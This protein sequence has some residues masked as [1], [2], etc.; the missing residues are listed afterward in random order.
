MKRVKLTICLVW[1][2]SLCALILFQEAGTSSGQTTSQPKPSGEIG[3]SPDFE[4][5][6]QA[7][8]KRF[9]TQPNFGMARMLPTT[10]QPLRSGHVRSFSPINEDE[11]SILAEF[12][13]GGWKVGIFLYGRTA[14]PEHP[15]ESPLENFKIRYRVNQ[16]VPISRGLKEKDLA[17]AKKLID[18]VKTAF[19][20]FQTPTS[21]NQASYQFTKG[22]W[23]YVAKPVRAAN[24]SCIQCHADYVITEM[25]DNKR[26]KFRKRAVGDVNGVI[27]YAFS[28]NPN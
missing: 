20:T 27:V 14:M 26:F 28:K 25:L 23:T 7:V 21:E 4:A 1:V 13:K 15:E 11:K 18:E 17:K 24:Q 22:D 19:V 8:Q 3:A 6:D 2:T 16:P 10:P 12:E 5:F 9:L